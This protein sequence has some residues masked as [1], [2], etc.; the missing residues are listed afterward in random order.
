MGAD[1]QC[2]PGTVVPGERSSRGALPVWAALFPEF[3]TLLVPNPGPLLHTDLRKRELISLH[4]HEGGFLVQARSL[5]LSPL[6]CWFSVLHSRLS[7]QDAVTALQRRKHRRA[8]HTVWAQPY[9]Q[10][11]AIAQ[12][13]GEPPLRKGSSSRCSEKPIIRHSEFSTGIWLRQENKH[14]AKTQKSRNSS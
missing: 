8:M 12:R 6:I 13:R 2:C 7:E 5:F 9:H 4:L 14:I 3:S 11:W 10:S 1:R